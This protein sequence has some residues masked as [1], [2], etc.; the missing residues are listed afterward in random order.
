MPVRWILIPILQIMMTS[1]NGNIFRVTGPL[2]GDFTGL[3]W[4]PHTKRQWRGALM[5]SLIYAW[6][7]A[8]VNNGEADLRRYRVHFDVTVMLRIMRQSLLMWNSIY[9]DQWIFPPSRRTSYYRVLWSL[10]VTRFRFR[11]SNRYKIRG[12]HLSNFRVKI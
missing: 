6:T 4:N 9:K 7:N 12:R 5:F 2:C 8:W 3:R 10:A 1:S 11:V